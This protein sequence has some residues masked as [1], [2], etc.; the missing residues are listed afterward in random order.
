M[1]YMTR[2]G[3][4]L[5]LCLSLFFLPDVSNAQCP[6]AFSPSDASFN[7]AGGKRNVGLDFTFYDLGLQGCETSPWTATSSASWVTITGDV[8]GTGNG[9]VSYIVAE[10]AEPNTRQASITVNENVFPITQLASPYPYSQFTYVLNQGWNFI[11]LPLQTLDTTIADISWNVRIIWSYDNQNKGWLKYKPGDPNNT[12]LTME[13][14]KGYWIYCEKDTP[15][16]LWGKTP[17]FF[18]SLF[19]GWNLIGLAGE[20]NVDVARIPE[21]LSPGWKALWNWDQGVWRLNW[22]GGQPPVFPAIAA[23]KLGK[24]YWLKVTSGGSDTIGPNGGTI[25][26]TA[27]SLTVPQGTFA[28][29]T[30]IELV[31]VANSNP[32][33]AAAV[34]AYRLIGLP[35]DFT[36]P[37]TVKMQL[38]TPYTE[39]MYMR[40]G[41]NVYDYKTGGYVTRYSSVPVTFENGYLSAGIPPSVTGMAPLSRSPLDRPECREM[42]IDARKAVEKSRIESC[43]GNRFKV[44]WPGPA[45]SFPR[46]LDLCTELNQAYATLVSLLGFSVA[47]RTDW[48]MTVNVIDLQNIWGEYA[49]SRLTVNWDELN[50]NTQIFTTSNLA[51][52][53]ETVI[54]EFFHFIQALYA[55]APRV[56]IDPNTWI[57]E[58]ASVW[59]Q[60]YASAD[61][62]YVPDDF[63]YNAG[64]SITLPPPPL[65]SILGTQAEHDMQ[66][67]HGY[68]LSI[69]FEYIRKYHDPTGKF[70]VK[71]FEYLKNGK[72]PAQ[73]I[74]R[75]IADLDAMLPNNWWSEYLYRHVTGGVYPFSTKTNKSQFS[76]LLI[77]SPSAYKTRS[78]TISAATPYTDTAGY[79]DLSAHFYRIPLT[80]DWLPDYK[81][82]LSLDDTGK[83]G[84]FRVFKAT[85]TTTDQRSLVS[86]EPYEANPQWAVYRDLIIDNPIDMK[87]K[88]QELFVVVYNTSSQTPDSMAPTNTITFRAVIEGQPRCGLA[89]NTLGTFQRS[90][91]GTFQTWELDQLTYGG[92][93]GEPDKPGT[94]NNGTYLFDGKHVIGPKEYSGMLTFT[95][96]QERNRVISF[97]GKRHTYE[98]FDPTDQAIKGGGAGI[99]RRTDMETPDGPRV[100]YINGPATCSYIDSQTWKKVVGGGV[101]YDLTLISY[102]CNDRSYLE[103]GCAAP[104]NE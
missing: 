13:P 91:D 35:A 93:E 88:N 76:P 8:S 31:P 9:I 6:P 90:S 39:D 97:E 36:K 61:P 14:Y 28:A 71:I 12:L 21:V 94:M 89:V 19:P 67:D 60:R 87:N 1:D 83:L 44:I 78:A 17:S 11:S 25:G 74:I 86:I 24:A 82:H 72:T 63:V 10:N 37:L 104:Y 85:T 51:V 47:P 56:G 3:A 64:E 69:L 23:F 32:S 20:D 43:S 68:G 34:N 59:A 65:T 41:I 75:T 22:N 73:A 7:A 52:L 50:F 18:T 70:M 42:V 81:I 2:F 45:A 57:D 54:H 100:Y 5:L 46:T 99:P 96:N 40:I 95:L 38:N 4:C 66:Q 103:I 53:K 77:G 26:N 29:D 79:P 48:P 30:P 55:P 84:E 16:S 49:N 58:A 62:E 92:V 27:F 80:T 98:I 15:F 102:V 101:G 33:E